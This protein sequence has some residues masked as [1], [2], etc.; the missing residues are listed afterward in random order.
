MIYV[1]LEHAM[2][3]RVWIG[4]SNEKQGISYLSE[5]IPAVSEKSYSYITAHTHVEHIG[6]PY[7]DFRNG[8]C[9]TT[10]ALHRP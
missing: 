8:H 10:S 5:L 6:L 2:Q 9:A 3:E 7:Q 1:K 4:I